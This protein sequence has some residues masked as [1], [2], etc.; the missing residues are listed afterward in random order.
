MNMDEPKEID[1]CRKTNAFAA[2]RTLV[3]R[4]VILI[5]KPHPKIFDLQDDITMSGL[6]YDVRHS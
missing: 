3:G 5:K 1:I 4:T 2:I 6:F